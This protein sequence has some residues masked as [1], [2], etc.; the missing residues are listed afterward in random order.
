ML[1]LAGIRMAQDVHPFRV[2]RHDPVLYSVM[3]H[4]DEVPSSVRAAVQVAELG[5]A[6]DFL[7]SRGAR[8]ISRTGRQRLEDRIEVPNSRYRSADHHAIT[9]LQPPDAATCS[10]IYVMDSLRGELLGAMNIVDIIRIT[11]ID[12]DVAALEV[13]GEIGDRLVDDPR[14]DH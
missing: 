6:A 4:L 3:D 13:R 14:R 10:D 9:A 2:G 1:L 7:S 5:G 12:Q 11:A 8:D